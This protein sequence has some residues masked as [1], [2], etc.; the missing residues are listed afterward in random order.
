MPSDSFNS[1]SLIL[2]ISIISLL[3]ALPQTIAFRP[4]APFIPN[5]QR[6]FTTSNSLRGTFSQGSS[7]SHYANVFFQTTI[8]SFNPDQT[9]GI[10]DIKCNADDDTI[11]LVVD[12]E[13]SR[14]TIESWPDKVM[15]MI[16]DKWNCF[17][18]EGAQFYLVGNKTVNATENSVKFTTSPCQVLK[19]SNN[20]VIDLNWE[21]KKKR[22]TPRRSVSRRFD[23]DKDQEIDLSALFDPNTDASSKPNIP[24]LTVGSTVSESISCANCFLRGNATVSLHI[25]G[26]SLPPK[27]TNATL[28]I[29]GNL[30]I[31]M[32][33]KFDTTLSGTLSTPDVQLLEVPLTPL[34]VPNLFNIGP[35]IIL[36]ASANLHGSATVSL[37]TGGLISYPNFSASASLLDDA[38][39][40]FTHAGFDPVITMNTSPPTV[41]LTV[42]AGVAGSLKP[43]L[44]LSVNV[45][46]GLL[47]AK[48]GLQVVTTLSTDATVGSEN[49]CANATDVNLA[50]TLTGNL[51]FFVGSTN[52]PLV[53]FPAKTLG[54]TCL[55]TS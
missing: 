54:S 46:D 50:T 51:G 36:A 30:D 48:T 43:Q 45:M 7:S 19:W 39:S 2:L 34:G 35:S 10:I 52:I 22:S 5:A 6:Q 1:F 17:G 29:N 27:I 4:L 31:N 8:P 3:T 9:E 40:S 53:N 13:A 15:V 42:S 25:E 37:T 38:A 26:Q 20:F 47:E 12:D 33:L 23:V 44:A 14:Q 41:G 18:K 28:S 24:L 21:H 49:N 11:T 32:D 16:N 55:K